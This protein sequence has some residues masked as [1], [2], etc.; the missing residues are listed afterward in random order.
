MQ[1]PNQSGIVRIIWRNPCALIEPL[2]KAVRISRSPS[3]TSTTVRTLVQVWEGDLDM[4]TALRNGSIKTHGLRHLI[5]TMPDWFGVCLYK[6]VRRGN[7]ELMRQA[8]E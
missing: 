6:E 1:T 4:R 8:A 3:Q 5:R 7:P 2:R